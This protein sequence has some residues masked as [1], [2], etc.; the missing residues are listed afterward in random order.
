MKKVNDIIVLIIGILIFLISYNYDTQVNLFFKD[1]KFP[2]FDVVFSTITNFSVVILI[3]LLVPSLILYKK[4]KK[5]VYLLWL[6]FFVSVALAFAVKLI[7]LRQRP[8]GAFTYPFISIINYSFPSMHAM[9]IFSLLPILAKHLN[10]QKAFWLIFGLLA[11]FSRVYF[12]FHFLSDVVFGALF[13][14]FL[15]NSLLELYEKGKLWKK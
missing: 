13:G 4:N 15:G 9:V 14:Y 7:F 12:G 3:M 1:I 8:I 10:K 6:T 11:A 2:V 5:I